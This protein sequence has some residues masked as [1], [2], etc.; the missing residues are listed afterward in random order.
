MAYEHN[1]NSLR[2]QVTK[3]II[4]KYRT[5]FQAMAKRENAACKDNIVEV[6]AKDLPLSCPRP[7]QSMWNAHPREYLPIEKSKKEICP[8]CGTIYIYKEDK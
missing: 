1:L 3:I 6:T 5:N 2:I 7:G 4:K 8:Y